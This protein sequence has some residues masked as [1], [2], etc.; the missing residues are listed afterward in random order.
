MLPGNC[1]EGHTWLLPGN[2]GVELRQKPNNLLSETSESKKYILLSLAMK[3]SSV[4]ATNNTYPIT[5]SSALIISHRHA[6]LS[7]VLDFEAIFN[8]L[9]H[10]LVYM[11]VPCIR[12]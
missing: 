11:N 5:P 6:C 9:V 1:G 7:V 4:T 2:Y 8:Y 10:C 3:S 12:N